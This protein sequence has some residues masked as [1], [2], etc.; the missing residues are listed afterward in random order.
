MKVAA[1]TVRK[2]P[3]LNADANDVVQ[4]GSTCNAEGGGEKL[5]LGFLFLL[6]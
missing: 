3:G 5:V 1:A 2:A 4:G 6:F